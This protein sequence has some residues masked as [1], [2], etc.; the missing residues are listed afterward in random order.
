MAGAPRAYAALRS[1]TATA[2]TR[3]FCFGFP[4]GLSI[5]PPHLLCPWN[6]A[7]ILRHSSSSFRLRREDHISRPS[8]PVPVPL[9]N[10]ER[11][12]KMA[13]AYSPTL[14]PANLHSGRGRGPI[15]R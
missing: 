12:E 8:L 10:P 6:A 9:V 1:S 11:F 15:H 3:D 2:S 14:A 4:V 7:L 13:L 5:H